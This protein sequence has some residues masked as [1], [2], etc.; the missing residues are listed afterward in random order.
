MSRKRVMA[1]G[2][3]V[4]L[5]V[6]TYAGVAKIMAFYHGYH[7]AKALAS[8]EL[9]FAL[10]SLR[11]SLEWHS[12]NSPYHIVIGRVIG[13]AL[14]NG[15]PLEAL[16]GRRPIELLGVGVDAVARGIALSPADAW[17]WNNLGSLYGN[18][19]V[20]QLRLERM[21]RAGEAA[22]MGLPPDTIDETPPSGLSL[23]DRVAAAAALK[24]GDLEPD[25]FYYTDFLAGLYW[26]RGLKEAAARE[27]SDSLALMPHLRLHP[28]LEDEEVLRELAEPVLEG[29]ERAASNRYL[30]P[31]SAARARA[32]VMEKLGRFEEAIEAM[33]EV[34]R[35][36]GESYEGETDLEVGRLE[37]RR[38][39]HE[40]S[41]LTLE[42]AAGAGEGSPAATEA[43]YQLGRAYAGL[44]RHREAVEHLRR[45][46]GLRPD[47]LKSYQE[48]ARALEALGESAEAERMYVAAVRRFPET[49]GTYEMVIEHMRRHGRMTEA[50]PYAE[51]LSKRNPG[52]AV[53]E[54]LLRELREGG[55]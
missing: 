13:T 21:R 14:A 31:S 3:M 30:Q 34:G 1:L 8:A 47:L 17:A 26:K 6:N 15:L 16:K 32:G 11:R 9:D 23:E 55:S 48:L 5:A 37:Q 22:A 54:R 51:A 19:H 25:F 53:A 41:L 52:N 40:A 29:I 28:L 33:Q 4:L 24:A 50:E 46:L 38:G 35:L 2:L 39:R 45:Y 43:L 27:L 7:G 18:F 42:R 10:S 44:S 12:E 20:A 36:G 49:P